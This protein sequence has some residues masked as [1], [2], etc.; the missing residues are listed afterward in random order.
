MVV[1]CYSCCDCV[2]EASMAVV[3]VLDDSLDRCFDFSNS[4]LYSSLSTRVVGDAI[5]MI[6]AQSSAEMLEKL[7]GKSASLVG[8]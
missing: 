2:F 5:G 6:N 4:S 8:V 7:G 1:C 3:S